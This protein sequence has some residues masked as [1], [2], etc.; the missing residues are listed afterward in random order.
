MVLRGHAAPVSRS[1]SVEDDEDD[2]EGEFC[3]FGE[4]GAEVRREVAGESFERGHAVIQRFPCREEAAVA[5][6][7]PG[8]L[9]SSTA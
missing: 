7:V 4:V 5:G 6:E 9:T 8:D 3:E 2:E 1:A